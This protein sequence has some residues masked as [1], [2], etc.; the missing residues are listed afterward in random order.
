MLTHWKLSYL[1][2]SKLS[3]QK[4]IDVRIHHVLTIVQSETP[5][6][7]PVVAQLEEVEQHMEERI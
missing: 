5:S 1:P 3:S 2:V 4:L 6:L 7:E